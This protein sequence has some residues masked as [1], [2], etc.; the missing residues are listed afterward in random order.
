MRHAS[1]LKPTKTTPALGLSARAST[2]SRVMVVHH[3]RQMLNLM[4]EMFVRLGYQV[5]KANDS[6]KAL[7]YFDRHPCDLVFTDLEMPVLDGYHLACRIKKHNPS[8]KAVVMTAYCQAELAEHMMTGMV[9]GWLFKPFKLEAFR[10]LLADIGFNPI[11]HKSPSGL[12]YR[13]AKNQ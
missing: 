3:N 11:A 1:T 12:Q 9:D 5:T 2:G 6:G 8:A 13:R 10:G 7:L 4:A